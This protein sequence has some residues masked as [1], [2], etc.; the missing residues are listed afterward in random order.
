MMKLKMLKEKY[1]TQ[2][3]RNVISVL[4]IIFGLTFFINYTFCEPTEINK[5]IASS[6]YKEPANNVFVD[7]NFYN[8]AIDEYNT[9]KNEGIA[10]TD[11]LT[12]EQLKEVTELVCSGVTNLSGIEKMTSLKKLSL[13][14]SELLSVDLTLNSELE[15][16]TLVDN[17]LSQIDLTN[18]KKLTSLDLTLPK[19][20]SIDLS[21]NVEL[22]TLKFVGNSV[23]NLDVSK[24]TKLVSL[25]VN[26]S[27]I[28]TIN[29]E[30]NILLEE[31]DLYI[32]KLNSLD[33][34]N[35][36]KLSILKISNNELKTVDLTSNKSLNEIYLSHIGLTSLDIDSIEGLTVLDLNNNNLE[37][38]NVSKNIFLR[39]L[40]LA[41][42]NV[43]EINL[44]NN[45]QLVDL[46]LDNNKIETLN[47]NSNAAI[48]SLI[49]SNNLLKELDLSRNVSLTNV[50]LDGNKFVQ[51]LGIYKGEAIQLSSDAVIFPNN[52]D[53]IFDGFVNENENFVVD[54][55]GVKAS[56]LG[57]YT[58]S[59]KY[60]YDLGS[61]TYPYNFEI[62]TSLYVVEILFDED[63][64]NI[65]GVGYVYSE[66]IDSQNKFIYT[67]DVTNSS[68]ILDM[69]YFNCGDFDFEDGKL[70][71]SENKLLVKYKNNVIK[72]FDLINIS[73]KDNIYEFTDVQHPGMYVYSDVGKVVADNIISN[74]VHISISNNEL[75]L[76]YKDG[77]VVD[78][79]KIVEFSSEKY[80][81][82]NNN[83]Y[84]GNESMD[85]IVNNVE[86]INCKVELDTNRKCLE[87]EKDGETTLYYI[88]QI[89][90]DKYDL[91]NKYLYYGDDLKQDIINNIKCSYEYCD[92]SINSNN[93]LVVSESIHEQELQKFSL[94]GVSSEKYKIGNDYVFFGNKD[95]SKVIQENG[96]KCDNCSL[97]IVNNKLVVSNDDYG[98]VK[99]LA[100]IGITSDKYKIGM[101]TIYV[102]EEDYGNADTIFANVTSSM[103]EVLISCET[104]GNIEIEEDADVL[105]P[106]DN[107]DAQNDENTTED[108]FSVKCD[109]VVIKYNDEEVFE[110]NISKESIYLEFPE[111]EV[112]EINYIIKKINIGTTVKALLDKI[113]TNATHSIIGVDNDVVTNEAILRTG[114]TLRVIMSQETL[115]Y[116]VSVKGDVTGSG[117]LSME[118]A[119]RISKHI[120]DKQ[121]LSKNVLLDAADYDNDGQIKMNDVMRLLN[122]Y[123][124]ELA[125]GDINLD[126]EISNSDVVI[127]IN[128]AY[129]NDELNYVQKLV[130][131]LNSDLKVDLND[132]KI[133]WSYFINEDIKL[134]LTDGSLDILYGDANLDG[135]VDN[136]DLNRLLKY[137]REE[138]EISTDARWTID[139]NLDRKIDMVDLNI[140]TKH[141][142]GIDEF[143]NL[144]VKDYKLYITYG[145]INSDGKINGSDVVK[146]TKYIEGNSED[147]VELSEIEKL[148]SDL[149]LDLDINETD[150]EI[151]GDYVKSQGSF[152][153]PKIDEDSEE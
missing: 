30:S 79:I 88:I 64:K 80:S 141:L 137:I 81:I 146:L 87:V 67:G 77:R 29:L 121:E 94:I 71:I 7:Q 57:S 147:S 10:Y 18:N 22:S 54:E 151:L 149:N 39:K 124:K 36:K 131:D 82:D 69:L 2:K 104:V 35:N 148:A 98:K 136:K 55:N 6:L 5:I 143:K 31:L 33:L 20:T 95:Y 101:D 19:I 83:I 40:N 63:N 140:L 50:L 62:E 75:I 21:N 26:D 142:L 60:K 23:G 49:V 138:M 109:S 56:E 112:D 43:S 42:N 58:I 11:S 59:G 144:P 152:D 116:A 125:L 17:T 13:D 46:N 85:E 65:S 150:L 3:V 118:S 73:S 153:L 129:G 72:Q 25:Y 106:S 4:V 32:G 145:D 139:L 74:N 48:Q 107:T 128:Y 117:K 110:Y 41:N 113:D 126:G 92:L 96:I 9:L 97:S 78:K 66:Y 27:K 103:G 132:A 51:E 8:C 134:P 45:K 102:G 100:I 38:I 127:L 108:D 93:E 68:S 123:K 52:I 24:N 130:A 15:S 70:E 34:S 111:L 105:G 76:V 89:S 120:I 135:N 119:K 90:S 84:V 115:E 1:L 37:E 133:L 28:T 44:D 86:C 12:D 14:S 99:E 122:D 91:S 61:S 114:D 16:L 47:L 53:V